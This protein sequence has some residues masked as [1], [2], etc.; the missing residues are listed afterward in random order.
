M[1]TRQSCSPGRNYGRNDAVDT[2]AGRGTPPG[3]GHRQ[4]D[5]VQYLHG[6]TQGLSA[7][8]LPTS[9]SSRDNS[10][11]KSG[12]ARRWDQSRIAK[13][14]PLPCLT[15]AAIVWPTHTGGRMPPEPAGSLWGCMLLW[16]GSRELG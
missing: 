16:S 2:A 3:D 8:H 6:V 15:E 1:A 5:D 14:Q 12:N 7:A 4:D 13:L 9:Y 10:M 11:S